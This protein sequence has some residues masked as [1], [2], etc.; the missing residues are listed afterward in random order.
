[1]PTDLQGARTLTML[2]FCSQGDLGAALVTKKDFFWVQSGILGLNF[3]YLNRPTVYTRVSQY[4]KW[5][6][7]KVTG[8]KPGF[9]TFISPGND[10]DLNYICP[11]SAPS[12]TVPFLPAY[13]GSS[14]TTATYPTTPATT[15]DNSIWSSG[16]NHVT[17]T[18]FIPLSGFVLFLHV[19]VGNSGI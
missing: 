5:I 1:M 12:T 16:A 7:N 6:S 14:Y 2:N 17:I 15:T 4:Q 10:S 11:T 8:M 13:F 19:F 18:H 9:I 3:Y